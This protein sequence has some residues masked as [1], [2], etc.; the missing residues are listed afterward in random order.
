M[1]KTGRYPGVFSMATGTIGGELSS[2]M[3]GVCRLIEIVQ[4]TADT[5]V[6]RIG[7]ITI[8]TSDTVIGNG[9]MGSV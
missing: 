4:V 8:M 9:R 1:V 7:I 6:G 3:V 5:G 2:F